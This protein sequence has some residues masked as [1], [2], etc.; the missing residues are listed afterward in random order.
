MKKIPNVERLFV[1]KRVKET[2]KYTKCATLYFISNFCT[3]IALS[4]FYFNF[5][6]FVVD[7]Q[8]LHPTK[9]NP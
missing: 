5:K 4:I 9:I 2:K 3:A 7:G 8:I 6:E 1:V